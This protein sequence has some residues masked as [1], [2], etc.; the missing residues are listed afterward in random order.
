MVTIIDRI[1]H[2]F[3]SFSFSLFAFC[4]SLSFFF[5]C[6]HILII[7]PTP[8]PVPAKAANALPKR[9]AR[10]T[11]PRERVPGLNGAGPCL[12]ERSTVPQGFRHIPL[13]G[14]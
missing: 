11:W 9:P 14:S 8:S 4:V 1:E 2:V 3:S 13:D 10:R 5:A 12:V 6:G 7:V